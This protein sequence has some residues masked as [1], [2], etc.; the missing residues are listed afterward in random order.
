[1]TTTKPPKQADRKIGTALVVEDDPIL[2]LSIEDILLEAGSPHVTVCSSTKQ[3]LAALEK[4]KP[5]VLVLDVHL[6]D[7][8]DGWAVAELVTELGPQPP[9]IV[10]S[11]GNPE[12]IPQ[13][14]A[15]LGTVL[16]KPYAP[17]ALISAVA[18]TRRTGL[19]AKIKGAITSD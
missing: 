14:I 4:S 12:A 10:F 3:A 13:D 15:E 9:R 11:T 1:M 8:D 18:G 17:E 5:D 19:L 16:A 2:A 7:R 6:V